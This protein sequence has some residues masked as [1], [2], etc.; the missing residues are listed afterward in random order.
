MMLLRLWMNRNHLHLQF[1]LPLCDQ[2][3]MTLMLRNGAGKWITSLISHPPEE[4]THMHICNV[5]ASQF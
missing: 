2:G 5:L 3:T 4:R 1:N